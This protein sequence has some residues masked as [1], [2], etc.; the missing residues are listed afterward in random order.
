MPKVCVLLAEGFEEIE[1]VTAIDVLR[2]AEIDTCVVALSGSAV[3]GSHG[4]TIE[5]DACIDDVA[6]ER[7]DLVY[8]PGGM[9]GATHLRDDARVLKLLRHQAADG[10]RIA[11]IC[12][13]PIA[14][15]RAGVLAGKRATSYPA[16]ERELLSVK[17]YSQERVVL[18]GQVATSRGPATAL[19]FALE[20]VAWLK[21]RDTARRIASGMLVL[22]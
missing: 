9:P 14:L 11:A 8:L 17:S 18:D 1:A 21:D 4:I 20:L 6:T 22:S 2:R 15:E 10:R 19:E 7:W 16:F 5:A 12:A 3:R 13:G